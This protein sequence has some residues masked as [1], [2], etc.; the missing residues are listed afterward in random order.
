MKRLSTLKTITDI[1]FVLAVIPAIFGLPF[2]LMAAIMPE[3]IP[4]KLNGD[5]F[6][7]INGAELIISLLVIYLSYALAVYALYLFKKV[8]ESFKKK[9]FFDEVVILSFNQM[10]KALLLSWT[11]G[12]LPS[13]YYNLVDG[14]I[15]ISIGFSDSL[16]T[17]GLGFFFIVLSDVFLMA[18]KQKEENDLTI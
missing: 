13:L 12:I 9:R 15:K 17:L 14:S 10:G 2:I 16:F 8:L 18:K 4:F 11:I 6:A 3:R 1:L 5:E 7:T